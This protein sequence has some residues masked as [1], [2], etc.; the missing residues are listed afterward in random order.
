LDFFSAKVGIFESAPILT[1]KETPIVFF[2]PG[3]G[4]AGGISE[5]LLPNRNK[6]EAD[7]IMLQA[8]WPGTK[9]VFIVEEKYSILCAS[10]KIPHH[11]YNQIGKYYASLFLKL[12]ESREGKLRIVGHSNGALKA[13]LGYLTLK[14]EQREGISISLI[15]IFIPGEVFIFSKLYIMSYFLFRIAHIFSIG[16]R[17]DLIDI[18]IF[19]FTLPIRFIKLIFNFSFG[20]IY[21]ILDNSNFKKLDY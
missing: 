11:A 8:Q 6:I 3:W 2:M 16:Y 18:L 10:S 12:K 20:M 21:K 9:R 7:Y 4:G 5:D 15:D 13:L 19:P 14:P 17:G 1:T